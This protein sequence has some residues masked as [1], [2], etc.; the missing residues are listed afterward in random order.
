MLLVGSAEPIELDAERI[1]ARFAAPGIQSALAEVGVTSPAALL[2]T[3]ITDRPGLERY[4]GDAPPVSDDRPLLEYAAWVRPNE[5][6][7]VLPKLLALATD[8]PLEHAPDALGKERVRER[9]VLLSLY[10]AGLAA[11]RG[12]REAWREAMAVVTREERDNPYYD[13]FRGAGR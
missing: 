12:D 4:V 13:W 10:E 6:L 2:A 1:G 7:H 9:A 5:I 8:P 11:Y 3:W